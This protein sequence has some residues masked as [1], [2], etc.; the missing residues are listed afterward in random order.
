MEKVNYLQSCNAC[1]RNLETLME[2]GV[3]L[4]RLHE[5][6]FSLCES[7]IARLYADIA[8][9]YK[10]D[11]K[12]VGRKKTSEATLT[13]KQE[14]HFHTPKEIFTLIS[15]HVQGQDEAKMA[16]ALAVGDH[17]RKPITKQKTANVL[18]MGRSGTGKTEIARAIALELNRPF[19][20]KDATDFT[21]AGYVGDDVNKIISDLFSQCDENA[22]L[23]EKAIVFID[24][25][26]KKASNSSTDGKI[27]TDMVQD[28]L[29]KL[30]EGKKYFFT[31]KDGKKSC[32]D[33]EKILFIFAG[34]FDGIEMTSVEKNL[35]LNSKGA[36]T[37]KNDP[38]SAITKFGLKSELVRRLGIITSTN[39]LDFDILSKIFSQKEN[40]I[41]KRF[42]K[43]MESYG[44]TASVDQAFADDICARASMSGLPIAQIEQEMNQIGQ[45]IVFDS[46]KYENKTI[47]ITLDGIEVA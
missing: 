44:I 29:L 16:V 2:E 37:R 25:L 12:K 34:A 39:P 46:E 19:L 43:R 1:D 23:A 20:F 9:S 28:G 40:S 22:E 5:K 8:P 36:I 7:C 38:R 18:I 27:G 17:L 42:V 24:E 14:I 10:T 47:K 15:K 35:G 33:T 45:S 26:D 41:E 30:I 3:A 32:V 31:T 11:S 6:K 21:T 4:R 13:Q